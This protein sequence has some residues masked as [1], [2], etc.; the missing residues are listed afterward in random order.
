M[1]RIGMGF[2]DLYAALPQRTPPQRT[3]ADAGV[4]AAVII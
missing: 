1:Q 2:D 4:E 3:R